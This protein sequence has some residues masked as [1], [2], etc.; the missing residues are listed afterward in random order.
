MTA[1]L[2]SGFMYVSLHHSQ[3][4]LSRGV[5]GSS[6]NGSGKVKGRQWKRQ[7]LDEEVRLRQQCRA[8]FVPTGSRTMQRMHSVAIVGA[9]LHPLGES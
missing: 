2:L 6:T 9:Q 5:E 7:T 8:A 1:V 4:R 3:H